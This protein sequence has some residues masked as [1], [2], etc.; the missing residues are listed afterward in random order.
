MRL[1]FILT[2]LVTD[3]TRAAAQQPPPAQDTPP[4]LREIS[5]GVF[6]YNGVQLDKKNHLISFPA[7]VNQNGGLVEYLLVNDL[8]KVHESL[9]STKIQPR[10]IHLALLLIGLKEAD[11]T[12]P[13]ETVPPQAIDTAYLQSAPKL[14]GSPVK[15]SVAW[16]QDGKQK[17]GPAEDWI[18]NLK[19]NKPMSAGPWTYNGSMI[20]NGVFLAT[21][22]LS[23][24]AVITDPTALVNNPRLGYDDD[25]IWQIQDKMVPPVDT[26]VVITITLAESKP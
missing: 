23:I 4:A 11:K 26:P 3:L 9:F 5:P 15:I 13:K 1:L 20:E 6:D 14:K 8:G 10:D 18:L 24:I 2:L 22:E 21:Q 12:N 7:A 19:T 17:S 16:T 25:Q